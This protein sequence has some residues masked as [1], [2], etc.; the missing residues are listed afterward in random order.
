MVEI[1]IVRHIPVPHPYGRFAPVSGAS[2]TRCQI[3]ALR[4]D[5]Q[6]PRSTWMCESGLPAILSNQRVESDLI[7][8]SDTK[9]GP[10]TGPEGIGSRVEFRER[11]CSAHPCAS[12]LRP[13]LPAFGAGAARRPKSLPAILSNPR[14]I[15]APCTIGHPLSPLRGE[16][17]Y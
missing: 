8:P 12:P 9:K 16:V 13:A 3:I 15:S 17:S 6:V 4:K 1:G 2:A 11:D 14:G 7:S 10:W 5:A